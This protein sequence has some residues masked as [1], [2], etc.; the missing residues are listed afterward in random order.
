MLEHKLKAA[1]PRRTFGSCCC[2]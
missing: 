1:L 2:S